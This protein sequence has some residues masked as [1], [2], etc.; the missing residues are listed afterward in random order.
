[1]RQVNI[2]EAKTDF[3]KLSSDRYWAVN[4]S[5]MRYKDPDDATIEIRICKGTLK[6]ST[7]V[8]SFDFFLHIVRNAR[9][10][11]WKDIGNLKLWFKGI[12]DKN[13]IDYIKARHAFEG[14]F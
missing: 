8:A 11:P 12:K 1:M 2:L 10:V 3:S 14:A 7:T 9:R 5:N 6:A 4:L 13:T